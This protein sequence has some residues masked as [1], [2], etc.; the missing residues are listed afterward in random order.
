MNSKLVKKISWLASMAIVAVGIIIF[1]LTARPYF[2]E[3][4]QKLTG[5]VEFNNDAVTLTNESIVEESN[6]L[7][8]A[9]NEKEVKMITAE[10]AKNSVSIP[11]IGLKNIPVIYPKT[12]DYETIERALTDGVVHL[13]N[14]SKPDV[15]TG[16]TYIIGH[17][18]NLSW[19]K[20]D[21][22]YVFK[23]L[24]NLE[25]GNTVKVN[26]GRKRYDYVVTEKRFLNFDEAMSIQFDSTK[27]I[28]V[29]M[30]CW[31]ANSSKARVAIIAETKAKQS[32]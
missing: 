3:V 21:Y 7:E 14:T 25:A 32:F 27:K 10:D 26:Y 15:D 17:S 22:N 12:N 8:E 16:V 13:S 29:L 5:K 1:A 31:P 9:K 2:N 30:T 19:V 18:S 28:L 23:D 20:G 24:S 6:V 4:I 11:T